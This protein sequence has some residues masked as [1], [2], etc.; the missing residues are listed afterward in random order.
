[1][2]ELGVDEITVVLQMPKSFKDLLAKT[3]W[4]DLAEKMIHVFERMADFKK[5]FGDRDVEPKAPKGYTKAYHYG[6]HPFYLAVG[7]HQYYIEMGVIVKFSAQALDYYCEISGLKVY[8][9]LKKIR[10]KDYEIRL[11]RIDLTADY[12]DEGLDTTEI[13]Q[14]LM[15]G[16]VA[17]FREYTCKKTGEPKFQKQQ[18]SYEGILKTKEVPTVYVGSPKSNSRLRI[19]DKKLEQ[20]QRKGT[21]YEKALGCSDWIRFE[22]IF[23]NEYSHQLTEELMKISDDNEFADLIASTMANKYR[24]MIVD[25]GVADCPTEYTQILIDCISNRDFKL[26]C[27]SSKNYDLVRSI[28]YIFTGSGIMS[29]LYK[30][31]TIWDINAVVELMEYLL[32]KLQNDFE[33]NEDCIYWLKKNTDSYKKC[34]PDMESFLMNNVSALP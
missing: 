23:R 27:P 11:S 7:Y 33:P 3:G 12:I 25:Q 17:L 9:F 34:Y 28:R 31:K 1:M 22:G 15:D 24:F 6:E 32:G 8:E 18:M 13:Y 4:A 29:T 30:V 16:K 20:I 14:S 5:I 19:Y 10:H 2:L 26:K 21:K